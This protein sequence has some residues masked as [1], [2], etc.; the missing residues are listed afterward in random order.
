[1]GCVLFHDDVLGMTWL[2]WGALAAVSVGFFVWGA[3]RMFYYPMRYPGGEW[4]VQQTLGAKDISLEASDGTKLHAWWIAAPESKLATLHLHGNGGNITHRGL[5]A[6]SIV[7]AGSSVLLLDYRGYGKSE[8]SP[9]EKGLYRDA[10]AAYDWIAAQGY[11]PEQ[12]VIHGESLGSAVAV[13]LATKRKSRGRILE[14]P[15][16][17]ARA[18]AGRV[19]PII[20]PM[21]VWGYNTMGRIANVHVPVF[22]IHG[23]ADEVIAYEFGQELYGAANEPKS[24]W[25]IPGATHND[26]HVVGRD[27]FSQRLAAFYSS[28]QLSH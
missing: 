18:V 17:S 11:A 13:D 27:E 5:S 8:G 19:F 3:S 12:I 26:L 14:A 1:M 6:R 15:F 22:I 21:L 16:T 28:L 10:E 23:D 24:F 4:S 20:G 9:S 7:G 2:G 25:T